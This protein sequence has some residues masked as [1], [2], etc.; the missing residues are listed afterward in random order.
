MN[1]GITSDQKIHH[2]SFIIILP[3]DHQEEKIARLEAENRALEAKLSYFE[4]KAALAE[5]ARRKLAKTV[6]RIFTG[7][8]L[9]DSVSRL[10][11]EAYEYRVEKDTIKDVIYAA[12]HRMTKVGIISLLLV[13]APF[14]L[15]LLQTY[16]LKKQNEKFDYQNRRIEQQTFLQEA[17]R[18]SSLIFL[19]DNVLDKMDQELIGRTNPQERRLSP[20]LIGRI[21][22]LSIALKPYRFLDGDSISAQAVS[23]ERGQLL[24]GLIIS[25]LSRSTYEQIFAAGDFSYATLENISLDGHFLRNINLSNSILTNVTMVGADFSNANFTGATLRNVRAF[26][27]GKRNKGALFDFVRFQRSII[28]GAD[29]GFCSFKQANFTGAR[30]HNVFF[31]DALL[32][33]VSWSG[34]RLDSL[35]FKRARLLK[36]DFLPALNTASL[37]AHNFEDALA[38]TMTIRSL[39]QL[40]GTRSLTLA[41]D[42]PRYLISRDTPYID[43]AGRPFVVSDSVT[44][45]LVG[46][47][48]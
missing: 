24:M 45:Y 29:F 20:Q 25:N 43:E 35:D 12:L 13:L 30:L 22:A 11:D 47:M 46:R 8:P 3:M 15:A 6:A 37:K 19:F 44:M 32:S 41:L 10:V 48:E 16:Y 42:K 2:S 9:R 39:Q 21:V 34:A 27:S 33:D 23:P 1:D 36:L 40:Q 17:E 14:S 31:Q 5:K 18:R 26:L 4:R 28:D 38:D 7:K